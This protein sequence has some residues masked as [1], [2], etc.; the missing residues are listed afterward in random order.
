[1][2]R[3][4]FLILL[5][6]PWW[7]A[8][9]ATPPPP[10]GSSLLPPG[11]GKPIVQRACIGCHSLDVVTSER[12]SAA[13]WSQLVNEM[14]GRGAD[15]SDPEINTIVKYL[16]SHFG[17]VRP[18][19]SPITPSVFSAGGSSTFGSTTGRVNV[20]TAS[21]QELRSFLGLSQKVAEAIVEYRKKNGKFETW[22]DVAA[23]PEAT[24]NQIE[25]LQDR[26]AF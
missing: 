19:T 9:Q 6:L 8:A 4:G 3:I 24:P 22:Q 23:V 26:L 25:H 16:S 1:M 18:R 10:R 7:A 14:I 21:A 17:A 12:G 13:H 20:N 2:R 5:A 11:A 15:L